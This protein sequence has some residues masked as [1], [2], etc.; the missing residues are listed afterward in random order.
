[1]SSSAHDLF[2]QIQSI[3]LSL[4][5]LPNLAPGPQI[6]SLLTRVVDL[7]TTPR[8]E[9]FT[10][11]VLRIKNMDILC[12]NLRT[13]CGTAEG[14]LEAYWARR[15]LNSPPPFPNL[16]TTLLTTFPYHTNYL[17]L[18]ALECS[19][20]EAFL[21]P[22][23]STTTTLHI[24]FLGSGPLPLTSYCMLDRYPHATV[25]N[26][27]RSTDALRVSHSLTEILGYAGRMTFQCL[28][29]SLP[30]TV[31]TPHYA[32][33]GST[34]ENEIGVNAIIGN[35]EGKTEGE[36]QDWGKFDIVFLAALV[37]TDTRSKLEILANVARALRPGTL[38][39]VRSAWGLRG[40]LYPV[41]E[42]SEEV[43]RIGFEVLV[44]VHPWTEV[45]NS[46]IVL[47]V[48]E[49]DDEVR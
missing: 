40:V 20:L 36:S 25:H 41:L 42:L 16:T 17:D 44:V 6:N 7:C 2:Q 37:G 4:I 1:M 11:Y 24:A 3:Y 38:V 32:K 18:S 45:V 26:I 47:R 13:I 30:L 48:R 21:P 27:D 29:V 43:F 34:M 9:E 31:T 33:N 14:E 23:S 35:G 49:R 10:N 15:F 8:S 12:A 39:V 22:S 46:V 19:A 28:D 5:R